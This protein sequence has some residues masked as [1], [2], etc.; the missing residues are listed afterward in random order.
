MAAEPWT[1]RNRLRAHRPWGE[2]PLCQP[3]TQESLRRAPRT[4][5]GT[6]TGRHRPAPHRCRDRHNTNLW[7]RRQH[8]LRS[9][10]RRGRRLGG[11]LRRSAA[12]A[13]GPG[14]AA[15]R[16]D[17]ALARR[18]ADHRPVHRLSEQAEH[19]DQADQEGHRKSSVII[20]GPRQRLKLPI[21]VRKR[22]E[23]TCGQPRASLMIPDSSAWPPHR[24]THLTR[25][26]QRLRGS[27]AAGAS[28]QP[29][30]R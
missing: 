27:D 21:S 3:D 10:S 25:L 24:Y 12:R 22:W 9:R 4:G 16:G 6:R 15:A 30:P 13:R 19:Q 2:P 18:G 14:F 1:Q 20:G 26:L 29:R 5:C 7:Q 28:G 8:L 17:P 11:R 23:T